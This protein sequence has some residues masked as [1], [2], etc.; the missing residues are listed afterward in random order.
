MQLINHLTPNE[1]IVT[2]YT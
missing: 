2:V 1:T